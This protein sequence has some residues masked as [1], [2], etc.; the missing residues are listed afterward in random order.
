LF[1]KINWFGSKS[2]TVFVLAISLVASAHAGVF[3]SAYA[4]SSSNSTKQLKV[5]VSFSDD[6]IKRGN[7]QEIKVRVTDQKTQDPVSNA[8]VKLSVDFADD[9]TTETAKGHTNNDGRITFKEK[10]D[11]GVKT[12]TF[13][14]TIKASKNGYKDTTVH[15]SFE[16]TGSGHS[17]NNNNNNNN[18]DNNHK[19]YN[20]NSHDRNNNYNNDKYNN[21]NGNNKNSN[22]NGNDKN[23]NNNGN[24]DG[25]NDKNNNDN[26]NSD[27]SVHQTLA[28]ACVN[29]NA[30]CQ[31]IGSQVTG[32]DNA[33]NVIGNQP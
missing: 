22:N 15:T 18:N 29:Q 30:P 31:N 21:N 5:K 9:S 20:N 28:Q 24:D 32:S 12:G 27:N 1:T 7:T 13:D 6:P 2:I 33:V 23:S 25:N 17:N 19:K 16:V 10:I 11:S 8:L 4:A 14:V 26:N 3:N